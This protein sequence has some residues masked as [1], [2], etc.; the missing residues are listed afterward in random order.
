MPHIQIFTPDGM[1]WQIATRAVETTLRAWFDEILP[2]CFIEGRPVDDFDM[3]YPRIMVSPMWAWKYGPPS[4]PDWLGDT[5]VIGRAHEFRAV[6]GATG[7]KALLELRQNLE[8]ELSDYQ[9]A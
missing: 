8:R 3:L 6:D 7:L 5:R 2:W 1:C 9:R 4:D